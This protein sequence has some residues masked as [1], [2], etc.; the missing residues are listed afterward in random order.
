MGAVEGVRVACAVATDKDKFCDNGIIYL[1][2]E[3]EETTKMIFLIRHESEGRQCSGG[4]L[5]YSRH[6]CVPCA[7]PWKLCVRV[8]APGLQ[9][10]TV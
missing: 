5:L 10:A 2:Q 8:T 9:E 7:K 4:R 6:S 1:V 3:R